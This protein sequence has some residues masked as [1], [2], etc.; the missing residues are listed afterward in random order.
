MKREKKTIGSIPAIVWGKPSEKVYLYV[1]GK[2]SQK[3]NAEEFARLAEERGYQTL[4]F[5][6]PG[7]GERA[8]EPRPCDLYHGTEDLDA[9]GKS[10]FQAWSSVSLY[11][12]SI[13]AFF[14]LHAYRDR[15][16]EK[17]LFQ[18]PVVD[19]EYLIGRMF[20][21]F[22]VTEEQLRERGEVPT[23][24]ETLSWSYYQYVR[25]HPVTRWPSPTHILYGER[26][27]LQSREVMTRFAR[28]FAAE[29]TVS[30]QSGHGFLAEEER[31]E[32]EAW[33]RRCL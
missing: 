14:S 27:T 3:E 32:E 11:G 1:H 8:E 13:G 23:P 10:V 20:Q 21:W 15:H 7:H 30:G 9:V 25:E 19:M 12:C 17:C 5:D 26:D 16:F 6:L 33:L 31:A 2:L 4:S 24:M 22:G 29:L 18:S 28:R